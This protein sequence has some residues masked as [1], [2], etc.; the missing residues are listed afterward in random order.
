[1]IIELSSMLI[2]LIGI[3]TLLRVR[4][5]L[6]GKQSLKV[7][8]WEDATFCVA[9][10]TILFCIGMYLHQKIFILL[11]IP[12]IVYLITPVVLFSAR[13]WKEFLG[14]LNNYLRR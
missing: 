6:Y 5:Y 8:P 14:L 12:F 1:M 7:G 3:F 9:S 13:Q 4:D 2:L 10:S 11:A